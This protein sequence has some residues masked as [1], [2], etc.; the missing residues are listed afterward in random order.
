VEVVRYALGVVLGKYDIL[1]HEFLFMGTHYHLV[2]T[3]RAGRLPDVLRDFNSIVS[4]SL[5]SIRGGRGTNFEDGYNIVVPTDEDR[6]LE[7]CVYTLANPC[8]ARL[9]SRTRHW[10]GASSFTL[11]YGVPVTV[12]RPEFGLWTP[13]SHKRTRAGERATYS[14]P[15][16]L[17]ETVT[18]QLAP[19]PVEGFA[20]AG[21]LRREVL[22]RLDSRELELIRERKQSGE[23]VLGMKGVLKQRWQDAP[24][25][26]QKMFGTRPT[27]SGRS[28]WARIEALGRRKHFEADYRHCFEAHHAGDRTVVWPFGTW[29]MVRRH[30]LPCRSSGPG[31]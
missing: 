22:K 9:V 2:L 10:R 19:P 14:K 13:A 24:H 21:D 16:Q 31:P 25:T 29:L 3:D 6:V 20:T 26:Q 17:P 23:P 11:K 28:R 15:S 18:L 8:S 4:R 1:I 27:V 7:H 5:N 12:K 30:A